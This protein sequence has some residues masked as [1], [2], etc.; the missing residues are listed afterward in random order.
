MFPLFSG[1]LVIGIPTVSRKKTSY[2]VP[3]LQSLVSNLRKEEKGDVQI[4]VFVAD[5]STEYRQ[6]VKEQVSSNFK[7][8]IESGLIIVFAAPPSFYPDMENLLP[9]FRRQHRSCEMEIQTVP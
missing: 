3:T 9:F 7:N 2:L 5:L 4:A 8:E 6:W 1:F